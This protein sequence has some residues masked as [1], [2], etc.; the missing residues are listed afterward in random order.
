MN[1]TLYR[2]IL[3]RRG[4]QSKTNILYRFLKKRLLD[5]LDVKNELDTRN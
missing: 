2:D 5:N 3:N 4:N 1:S